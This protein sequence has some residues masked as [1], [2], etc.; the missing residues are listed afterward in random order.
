[1]K[2]IRQRLQTALERALSPRCQSCGKVILW[3][4]LNLVENIVGPNT[5]ETWYMGEDGSTFYLKT[6][7]STNMAGNGLFTLQRS[8]CGNCRQ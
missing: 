7:T 1:M 5:E 8:T 6:I 4:T 3:K 2:E